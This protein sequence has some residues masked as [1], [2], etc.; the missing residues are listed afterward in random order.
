VSVIDGVLHHT[1][2]IP[3]QQRPDAVV[4][5]I[6]AVVM[7]PTPVVRIGLV[8]V[9]RDTAQI[10]A[11]DG[12]DSWAA[13]LA[14]TAAG[15]RS[16]VLVDSGSGEDEELVPRLRHFAKTR[17][18]NVL[19]YSGRLDPGYLRTIFAAGVRGLIHHEA[20]VEELRGAAV[21]VGRGNSYL[22]PMLGAS[23]LQGDHAAEPS[24]LGLSDR[25]REVVKLVA[26][27]HT[28]R[29]IARFLHISIRTVETHLMHVRRKL[30][31][32]TRAD[33]VRFAFAH[34]LVSTGPGR[35]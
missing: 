5:G 13:V 10:S 4:P 15:S 31:L 35:A 16:L 32:N 2:R 28:Q 8:Q 17:A 29:E 30:S 14:A 7:A 24:W 22:H 1:A 27:G 20:S 33:V 23:L 11:V 3:A 12:T 25:E 18:T 9:L 34:R 26:I 21:Y 6:D 19:L